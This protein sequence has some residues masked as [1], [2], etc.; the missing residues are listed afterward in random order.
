[1]QYR[2]IG[3]DKFL[4]RHTA[5]NISERLEN[6]RVEFELNP[7]ESATG[8]RVPS[9]VMAVAGNV[10]KYFDAEAYL[11]RPS[12][13]TDCGSDISSGVE[14]GK[15]GIGINVCAISCTMASDKA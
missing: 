9:R 13:T 12:I 8:R 11:D 4:E 7:I 14:V 5:C 15:G 2:V 10:S 6:I 3:T 1:M